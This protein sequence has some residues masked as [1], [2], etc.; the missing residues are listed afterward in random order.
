[1]KIKINLIFFIKKI[2]HYQRKRN[3]IEVKV[4]IMH[5]WNEHLKIFLIK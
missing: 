4:I 3:L 5:P 1:M 2:E